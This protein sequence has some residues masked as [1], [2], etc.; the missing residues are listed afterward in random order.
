MLFKHVKSVKKQPLGSYL[1]YGLG[2]KNFV[3]DYVKVA[4]RRCFVEQSF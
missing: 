2:A 1:S 3:F 4:T